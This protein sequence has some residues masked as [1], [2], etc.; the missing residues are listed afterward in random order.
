MQDLLLDES[1]AHLWSFEDVILEFREA[2]LAFRGSHA[3][4]GVDH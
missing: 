1:A 3:S 4:G 2:L